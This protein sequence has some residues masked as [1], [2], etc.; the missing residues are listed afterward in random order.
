MTKYGG[1][2]ENWGEECGELIIRYMGRICRRKNRI[3]SEG[4][5]KHGGNTRHRGQSVPGAQE[6]CGI[7]G[8][9][10]GWRTW[11]STEY[12]RVRRGEQVSGM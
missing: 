8:I 10:H 1:K 2:L 6:W 3:L 9:Y 11:E 5:R 7:R 12:R 4:N